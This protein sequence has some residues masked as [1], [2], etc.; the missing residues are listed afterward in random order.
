MTLKQEILNRFS[1]SIKDS[2]CIGQ[3]MDE[4]AEKMCSLAW[5]ECEAGKDM[6]MS[7]SANAGAEPNYIPLDKETWMKQNFPID[8][9]THNWYKKQ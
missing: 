1:A 9:K 2:Q 8:Y 6:E 5:D 7:M 4:Y 3:M